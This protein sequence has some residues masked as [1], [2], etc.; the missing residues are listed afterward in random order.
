LVSLK[1]APT[2]VGWRML[3]FQVCGGEVAGMPAGLIAPFCA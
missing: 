1:Y 2:T 3:S